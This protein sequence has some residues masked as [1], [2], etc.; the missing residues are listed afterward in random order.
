[1]DKD[2]VNRRSMACK[3][4]DKAGGFLVLIMCFVVFMCLAYFYA[5]IKS[6]SPIGFLVFSMVYGLLASLIWWFCYK[7]EWRHGH[8]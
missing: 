8:L 1:M 7:R 4:D 3:E 2:N 6:G 5:A